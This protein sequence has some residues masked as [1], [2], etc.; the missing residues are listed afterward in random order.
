[1][2]DL[3]IKITDK[4]SGWDKLAEDLASLRKKS[5]VTGIQA[6]EDSELLTI[7]NVNEFGADIPVTQ[8]TRNLF[9]SHGMPLRE[10]TKSIHI[11]SRPFIRQTF[12]KK[13]K[14]LAKIGFK[15]ARLI[16]DGKIGIDQG[17]ELW[18]DKFVSM[19]RSEVADG[20]N[21]KPNA[22]LTIA[23]KGG[24]LQPLQNTGR[25]MQS[26]KSVVEEF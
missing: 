6:E 19:I 21:F 12:S 10:A 22:P 13:E 11:P 9:R 1:M 24:G 26:L 7:A 25:L 5:V 15:M 17:L 23:I 8:E 20:N 4:D 18:G 2:L 16:V 3:N 14:E